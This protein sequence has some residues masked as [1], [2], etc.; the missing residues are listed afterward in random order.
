ML[1]YTN[2]YGCYRYMDTKQ[3]LKNNQCERE[4]VITS[5]EISSSTMDYTGIDISRL[6]LDSS[7]EWIDLDFAGDRI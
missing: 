6:G 5:K 3:F 7:G 1:N 4:T 2:G